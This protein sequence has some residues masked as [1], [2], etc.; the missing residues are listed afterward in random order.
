MMSPGVCGLARLSK[1]GLVA[2]LTFMGVGVL[3]ATLLNNRGA[4]LQPAGKWDLALSLSSEHSQHWAR[5]LAAMVLLLALWDPKG[6]AAEGWALSLASLV[7]GAIFAVG[8]I[9]GQMCVRQK[10]RP[11][12]G[13]GREAKRG[14]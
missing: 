1:R 11:R 4:F 2:V 6:K 8:L 7:C 5:A 14:G 10:V 12:R 9:V 13:G 3:T